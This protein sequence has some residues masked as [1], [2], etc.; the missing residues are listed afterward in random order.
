MR[1]PKKKTFETALLSTTL[2]YSIAKL[3]KTSDKESALLTK[4][5]KKRSYM[6]NAIMLS[7]GNKL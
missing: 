7:K 4:T 3:M 2:A 5:K 6:A 1:C